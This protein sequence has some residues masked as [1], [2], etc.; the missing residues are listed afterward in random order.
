MAHPEIPGE[1]HVLAQR[2]HTARAQNPPLADDHSAVVHGRLDEKDVFKKLVGNVRV[3]NGAAA[4]H[5]VQ[6]DLPLEHDQR[7]GAG[8]GHLRAG[9]DR[10]ADHALQRALRLRPGKK[11]GQT[12]A[13]HL[14]EHAPDL[15]L[16]QDDERQN[17]PFHHPAHD[18]ANAGEVEDRREPQHRQKD[19]NAF[20]QVRHPRGLDKIQQLVQNDGHEQ[21]IQNIRD[22][23]R[24]QI[25]DDLA[26]QDRELC[27]HSSI[28]FLPGSGDA[29]AA[30]RRETPKLQECLHY[31]KNTERLQGKQR[32]NS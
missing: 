21:D 25:P 4:H 18:V 23:D 12:A 22:F 17:A 3:Q 15:R 24:H 2:K 9:Q 32:Q 30:P 20:E 8:L 27:A 19:Q 6:Q 29:P 28:S 16:K 11:Q 7:A 1:I 5:V 13:A 14:L 10:L 26:H 31:I